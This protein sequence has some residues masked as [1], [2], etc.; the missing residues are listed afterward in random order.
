MKAI[1]HNLARLGSISYLSYYFAEF[2]AKQSAEEIDSIVALSAALVSEANQKGNVCV[3]FDDYHEQPLFQCEHLKSGELPQVENVAQWRDTLLNSCCVGLPGELAPLIVEG[4]RLYLHRYWFYET[5]VAEN[6]RQRLLSPVIFNGK[7]LGQQI[8]RLYTELNDQKRAVAIAASNRFVVVS[9]GPG[10]GKTTTIINILAVLLSQDKGARIAL[11]APTGKA[12]ARMIDSIQA[13]IENS[14]ISPDIRELIP[15]QAST[16]HRL[17]GYQ[18]QGFRYSQQ[19]R[20]PLDCVVID[21][22]SMVDLTLMYRLLDALPPLARVILLGDRDQLASVA[23]G[24]VL[25]DITGNRAT[26][27]YSVEQ[28]HRLQTILGEVVEAN[29]TNAAGIADAIALLTTSYRFTGATGI[30]QL[31]AFV[32]QGLA[33]AVQDCLLSD[34]RQLNWFSG[35]EK[36]PDSDLLETMLQDYKSVLTSDNLSSAFEAFERSRVLCAVH[37]GAFGIDEINQR[38]TDTMLTRGW[39]DNIINFRGKPLLVTRNDYEF[40]LFNGDIGLLWP[41][42]NGQLVAWF[43]ANNQGFRRLPITSLPEHL[44]AWAMTVHKS[45]GSEFDTVTLLLPPESKQLSLSRE[46]LYTGITRAKQKLTLIGTAEMLDYAC[47]T[48]SH[49]QSGLATKL[50]WKI[51]SF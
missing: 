16:I 51:E 23:A 48:P 28:N 4:N 1:L 47:R 35:H 34:D 32:N 46:L 40:N 13:G 45:Q 21:E 18:Q 6:I 19:H 50:G 5:Q 38:I 26:V 37:S 14:R 22:A 33:D 44:C 10:T 43:R 36:A 12:A 27:H 39:I 20:L 31:A 2:I 8:N 41:D 3:I 7:A 25:G 24:N 30:S 11:A 42:D 17:L 49:R 9:G 15:S 29:P